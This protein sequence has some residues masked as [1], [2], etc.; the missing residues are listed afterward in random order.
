MHANA[1]D[2]STGAYRLIGAY[3]CLYCQRLGLGSL[4]HMSDALH[5]AV[6]DHLDGLEVFLRID[7]RRGARTIA[8]YREA[9]ELFAMH[10]A[11]EPAGRR[12][13]D[14]TRHDCLSYLRSPSRQHREQD[15]SPSI[16]NTRLSALRA[17]YSYLLWE[18]IVDKDPTAVIKYQAVKSLKKA[19][20][21]FDEYLDVAEA[22]KGSARE[23]RTRDAAIVHVLYHCALRV[24]E[25]VSLDVSQIVWARYELAN[26][27]MKG[28]K[29]ENVIFP[30]LVAEAL[31][32]YLKDPA[33][34]CAD[35]ET[36]LF[37]NRTG[38]RLSVRTV[39]Q[40]MKTLG[41]RAGYGRRVHPH[42]L[43]RSVATEHVHDGNANMRTVADI[44]HHEKPSTT[45]RFYVHSKA[46]ADREAVEALGAKAALR[47]RARRRAAREA[48]AA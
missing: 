23:L 44:L 43:R 5:P 16:W 42:L 25:L 15:V 45:E 46:G 38:S 27:R 40:L 6:R 4:A 8:A 18:E 12:A 39:Q 28:A 14:I 9:L 17:F 22:S 35:G 24:S 19:P 47:I 10:L 37:T 20:L 48:R 21:E 33:R 26:V 13:A 11:G 34:E 31:E 3:C 1:V 2:M 30:D 32:R 7:R 41:G 36:A 29:V